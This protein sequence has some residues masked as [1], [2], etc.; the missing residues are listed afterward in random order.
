MIK[1]EPKPHKTITLHE[2]E[3]EM[4]QIY[5]LVVAKEV[6]TEGYAYIV[7]SNLV[8]EEKRIVEGSVMRHVQIH[9]I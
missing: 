2:A 3:V 6:T 4:D 7:H 1:I 8:G 5:K 9:G